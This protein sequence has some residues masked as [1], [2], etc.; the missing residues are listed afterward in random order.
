MQFEGLPVCLVHAADGEFYAFDDRCPHEG[1][2]LCE[3]YLDGVQVE[4]PLHSSVFDVRTGMV[5]G[6][7]TNNRQR[8]ADFLKQE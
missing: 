4:C 3:G 5:D 8:H 2:S 6:R 7:A 1:A